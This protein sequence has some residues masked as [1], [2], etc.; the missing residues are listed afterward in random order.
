MSAAIITGAAALVCGTL[1]A[2]AYAAT[3]PASVLIT[4]HDLHDGMI[5]QDGS[6]YYLYGTMYKCGFEWGHANT[7]FCGFGVESAPS[8]SG[9]WTYR[10]ML[11][12]P[13][14]LDNWGPDKGKTWDWVCGSTGAGCFNPRMMLR[15]DGVWMLWFNAPLDSKVNHVSAYYVMGCNG[16]AGP[17]G[18]QAG[19]PHG[20]THK[21]DL[22]QCDVDGDFSIITS[23]R[24]A[25]IICSQGTLAEEKLDYWWTDGTG[26]GSTRLAGVHFA[27]V[28]AAASAVVGEGVG[29]YELAD[30]SWEM[31][32]STPGCGYCTGPPLLKSVGG[33]TEV[34]AGYSTA[35]TML[36]PWTLGTLPD[37]VLSEAFCTGQPRTV[38]TADSQ[39]WEWIDRWTGSDN[40]TKASIMLEPM[41]AS[42]TVPSTWTCAAK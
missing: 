11:F 15:P 5:L 10:G 23:G 24:A 26:Q 4:G 37:G 14:A 34:Q 21:P 17:C 6:T 31:V 29:A 32:Y 18:Y 35:P 9:P 19:A 1:A 27:A 22:K 13:K 2:P 16:P 8:L 3:G 33:A 12:S 20:S 28:S 36:G 38:L 40:E 39:A 41:A 7:P 42:Q 30:G 25:A